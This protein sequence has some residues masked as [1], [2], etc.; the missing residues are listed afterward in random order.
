MLA[1]IFYAH[2]VGPVMEVLCQQGVLLFV[3]LQQPSLRI[4]FLFPNDLESSQ[5][6]ASQNKE[7]PL[8][9]LASHMLSF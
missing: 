1:P 5:V 4:V 3:A 7:Q 2:V 9:K 8:I 6:L